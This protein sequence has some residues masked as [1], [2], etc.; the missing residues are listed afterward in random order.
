MPK[1]VTQRAVAL[2]I[3]EQIEIFCPVLSSPLLHAGKMNAT[4]REISRALEDI[5]FLVVKGVATTAN[6]ATKFVSRRFIAIVI[7][8]F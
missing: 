1:Q 5:I 8:L 2:G 3:T 7:V 4:K 6:K